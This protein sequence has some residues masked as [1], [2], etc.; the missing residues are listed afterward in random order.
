MYLSIHAT[1]GVLIG[2]Y[3]QSSI[4]A[5]VVGFFSHFL[6]DMV[7][8]RDGQL[9]IEDLSIK[10]I[11]QRYFDKLVAIVYLDLGLSTVVM[12][13]LLTN[14]LHFI[15]PSII[16]GIIGSIAPDVIQIFAFLFPKVKP[17]QRFQ[18]LHNT[19]H[20]NPKRQKISLVAGHI[21]QLLTLLLCLKPLV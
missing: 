20:Y 10:Q 2:S 14:N 16:W 13:A 3:T 17:L 7:P 18:E 19:L 4:V 6:L 11:R 8:H 21:T 9:P 15:T 1:A 5:F 12:A